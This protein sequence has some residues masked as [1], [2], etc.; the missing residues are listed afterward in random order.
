MRYIAESLPREV[1]ALGVDSSGD[2]EHE[3]PHGKRSKRAGRVDAIQGRNAGNCGRSKIALPTP[4]R[5]PQENKE[6]D[7]RKS[8]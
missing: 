5:Q 8:S 6:A 7:C 3:V 4:C 2:L 1:K